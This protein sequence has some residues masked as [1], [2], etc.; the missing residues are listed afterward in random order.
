M[1]P[2]PTISSV[3]L[4]GV[5]SLAKKHYKWFK[6]C[7][8]ANQTKLS[9]IKKPLFFHYLGYKNPKYNSFATFSV[10]LATNLDITGISFWSYAND[11]ELIPKMSMVSIVNL[12]MIEG[13]RQNSH[14]VSCRKIYDGCKSNSTVLILLFGCNPE[15]AYNAA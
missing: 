2:S 14:I 12:P 4:S 7:Y 11:T 3:Y 15:V 1:L 13:R 8:C 9:H 10:G 5:L 6:K